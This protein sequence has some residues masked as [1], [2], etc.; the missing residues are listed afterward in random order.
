MRISGGRL[1]DLIIRGGENIYP[2]EIENVLRDHPKIEE[3]AVVAEND[4]YYGEIVAAV[5]KAKETVALEE[6]AQ[7]CNGKIA[8]FKIP[9]KLYS[10]EVFPMTASGKI[11]KNKLRDMISN[12]Q[13]ALLD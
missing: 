13:L 5:I 8:K 12:E 7:F 4:R 6:L 11:Q 9:A 1:K 3:I 2:V 10:V